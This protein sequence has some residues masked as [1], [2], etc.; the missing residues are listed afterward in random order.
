MKAVGPLL[1]WSTNNILCDGFWG[2]IK[3]P[4]KET[5]DEADEAEAG[6]DQSDHLIFSSWRTSMLREFRILIYKLQKQ[7][8]VL[9]QTENSNNFNNSNKQRLEI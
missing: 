6:G 8:V 2:S 9:N 7:N 3:L 1:S 5:E 4:N